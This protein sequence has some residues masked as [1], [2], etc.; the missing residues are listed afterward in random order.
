MDVCI[1]IIICCLHT[2]IAVLM[3]IY[4]SSFLN[5]TLAPL[6]VGKVLSPMF[7]LAFLTRYT[8]VLIKLA[9]DN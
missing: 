2:F 3:Y 7:Y 8:A 6:R 1:Y 9:M 4:L 5:T